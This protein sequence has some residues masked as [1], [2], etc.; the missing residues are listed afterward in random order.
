MF[1]CDAAPW[2]TSLKAVSAIGTTVLVGVGYA[3]AR[4]IP[5]GT[6]VPF[7][8]TFGT[9]V[10]FVP[11]LIALVAVLFVVRGYEVGPGELRVGR[12]LFSTTID[13]SGLSRA[14][15]DPSAMTGSLRMFG[16][17][18]LYSITGLFQSP[19]LGRYRAFVT[20]PK[21]SVVLRLP[22]RTVVISPVDP[23]SFLQQLSTV[24]P[25]VEIAGPQG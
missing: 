22:D 25:G 7:A 20:D 21:R 10:S 4:A 11:P 18:G 24:V 2:P 15:H 12:L 19:S 6:R 13:L 23:F 1:R 3:T 8:E 9:L 16:N 5:R 17:G 14:W